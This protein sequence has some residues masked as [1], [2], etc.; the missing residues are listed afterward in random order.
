MQAGRELAVNARGAGPWLPAGAACRKLPPMPA[1]ATS[2]PTPDP[3]LSRRRWLPYAL[4]LAAGLFA[5]WGVWRGQ[6][7][8]DDEPAI[9]GN[10]A[11]L[12]G[13]WWQA[14]FGE[15]HQ[16]LANRPLACASLVLDLALFGPGP[17]GPHLTNLL[18]HLA[19]GLLLLVTLRGAL[20]APNLGGRWDGR[21]AAGIATATAL[22]WVAHP[23]AG[24]AVAYATQRSTVLAA[25][26]L[27]CAL[28]ATLR[29]ARSSQPVRW[30]TAAVL[31]VAGAMA[32]KEDMVAAPLLVLLWER[33][34]VLP[35]WTALRQ[36]RGFVVAL[37]ATWLV[38][39]V[40]VALGPSNPTVG[41]RTD[42]PATAWQW[43]L[44]QAG[45]L[46]HYLRLVVWPSPLRGA[47]DW[48]L[49]RDVGSAALPGLVVLTLLGATVAAW[50][51]R[52][53]WGFLGAWFFLLLGATSSVLPIVTEILA[54]RRMYLPMLTVLLPLVLALARG[55][56]VGGALAVAAAAALGLGCVAQGRVAAHADQ[57]V[58]W[59]DA[60]AKRD[61]AS[62][63]FLARQI[64]GNYGTTLWQQGRLDEACAVFDACIECEALRPD[65]RHKHALA[66]QHRGRHA[67]ALVVLRELV[68][69]RP[70]D[71]EFVGSLGTCLA[72]VVHAG[73]GGGDDARLVEAEALLRRS[74]DLE[75]D[76][77]SRWTSLGCVLRT[78]G[79]LVDAELAYRRATEH[80]DQRLQPYTGRAEVLAQLGRTAEI[81]PMF[82]RLLARR[83]G[84][85]PL[86]LE[87]ADFFAGK[88][89]PALAAQMLD[90][91]LRLQP[92]NA[93]ARQ[94]L[95][96]L[97]ARPR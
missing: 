51:R 64:L 28:H 13:D 41:Y 76:S 61:P 48:G 92:G 5:W 71:A 81:S 21:R 6:F 42:P 18:L 58:F 35:T 73:G 17:F 31:A 91:V 22:L 94:R 97:Q 34:F 49:V 37:A 50:R 87:L 80:T 15:P 66:L 29:A 63:T 53:W 24:D 55:C 4:V 43:L 72:E 12:A 96:Q 9:V 26:C 74:L 60:Y 16:P 67:E 14:A 70:D 25:T 82:E 95:Q 2:S 59:A 75:P 27:L 57:F 79:R 10:A 20:Q 33:A 45:V 78:R 3:S 83:P 86:R 8:F 69:Q 38:L 36:R 40:C 88:Q 90:E 32:S 46:V 65:D 62:R 23:L 11:L 19:N 56:G 54:E 84:D 77:A 1:A 52:P 44:T 47:Y 85:V 7:V 68:A 39:L 89:Q 30:R 93:A